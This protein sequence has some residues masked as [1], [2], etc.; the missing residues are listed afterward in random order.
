[1]AI[2]FWTEKILCSYFYLSCLSNYWK[3]RTPLHAKIWALE[4][5]HFRNSTFRYIRKIKVPENS[6]NRCN[7][8]GDLILSLSKT[9]NLL[10]FFLFL[11][12]IKYFKFWLFTYISLNL[13]SNKITVYDKN[14]FLTSLLNGTTGI[15]SAQL[16]SKWTNSN[17]SL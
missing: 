10:F 2:K 6:Y 9:L 3:H 14:S 13:Y 15:I 4:D 17:T 11:I 5:M 12:N 16:H 8:E 1:M 7:G